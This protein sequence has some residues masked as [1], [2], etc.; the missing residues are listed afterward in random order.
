V[1]QT[2]SATSNSLTKWKAS[3]E[4]HYF[5]KKNDQEWVEFQKNAFYAKF[6]FIMQQDDVVFLFSE[7]RKFYISLDSREAKWGHNLNS[8]TNVFNTGHWV[9]ENNQNNQG[10]DFSNQFG[11]NV[12]N[13]NIQKN[14]SASFDLN[15][16]NI[17]SS[18]IINIQPQ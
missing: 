5:F 7:D 16:S 3:E 13:I 8:L 4:G 10:V 14:P 9:K 11:G 12:N 18:I 1:T 17:G 2:Q 6:K 15:K